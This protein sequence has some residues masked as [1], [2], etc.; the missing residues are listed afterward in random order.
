VSSVHKQETGQ[1]WPL[2]KWATVS[3]PW[4]LLA[5]G[6]SFVDLPGFG[7]ANAVRNRVAEREYNR[8][9]F[10]CVCSRIDRA[11]TDR[12]SLDWLAKAVRDL[13]KGSVAYACTKSDDVSL[14]E[15][16]RDNALPANT[17]R[18]DAAKVRNNK[19][20]E[21]V[22]AMYPV[23]VYTVSAR[24]FA[25]CVGRESS[26]PE[27]FLNMEST[28]VPALVADVVNSV[29][30][31]KARHRVQLITALEAKLNVM[32][33]QLRECPGAD[34]EVTVLQND[35]RSMLSQLDSALKVCSEG[36]QR[37]LS[38]RRQELTTFAK[39]AA[40]EGKRSLSS[41][42][43][44]YG[45]GTGLHWRRHKSLIDNDGE[46]A[47]IDIPKDV[48]APVMRSL[49]RHWISNFN[50]IPNVA[51]SL[52]SQICTRVEGFVNDFAGRLSAWPELQEHATSIGAAMVGGVSS[53][54]EEEVEDFEGFLHERRKGYAEDVKQSAK[55]QL[56]RH[57]SPAKRHCG[58][59]SFQLRKASVTSHLPKVDLKASVAKPSERIKVVNEHFGRT[60]RSMTSATCAQVR[61]CYAGFWDG[62]KERSQKE[63]D[64]KVAL[65]LA[66]QS[67]LNE[68]S[69]SFRCVKDV[70]PS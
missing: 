9:D 45:N 42:A 31:R 48:T 66:L 64:A 32:E 30:A 1:L 16:V 59:G 50:A 18:A 36:C 47:G 29:L 37:D 8:A 24:D 26:S 5:P 14:D 17:T 68:L 23:N 63:R 62:Q 56:C 51:V 52:Q 3:G 27:T 35:F 70:L 58:T 40:A 39:D 11:A 41:Q 60:S 13:P 12:A 61:N 69:K 43:Q 4:Q 33:S 25:R 21:Q 22:N 34:F 2:V 46:W 55:D 65:R 49:D 44:H 7:D 53:M 38:A 57:L 19:V 6:I 20:K 67:R 10:V 15:V 54:L 28:E